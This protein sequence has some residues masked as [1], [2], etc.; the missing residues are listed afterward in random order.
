MRK[1]LTANHAVSH[2]VRLARVEVIAAYPITPQTPIVEELSEMCA[3]GGLAAKFI[4]VESEHSAMACCIGAESAGARSFTATSSQGLALMHEL[5]HW[6]AG[7]RL[8]IVMAEVNRALAPGWN[9]WADQT[10]SLAQRDTGWL[11]FYCES[12]QEVLDTVLIAY[13]VAEQA[14]LPAMVVYDAFFLSHTAEVVE[15][16]SQESVD[17]YLPP[18]RPKLELSVEAPA[19]FGA[20][21]SPDYFMEFRLKAEQ[22]MQAAADIASQAMEEFARVFGRRYLPLEPLSTDDA[23]LILVV[24]GSAAS[25]ARVVVDRLRRKGKRV[26]LVKIKLFRPSPKGEIRRVLGR[27]PRVAV[28]D[29]NLSLGAGGIFAQEIAASLANEPARP[30]IHSY[31]AGLGGRDITEETFEEIVEDALG[32]ARPRPQPLW[33]GVRP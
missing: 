15:V 31:I 17:R 18:Y 22:A 25:T 26:G 21:T 30:A 7:A 33:V 23:E 32:Q 11:Q 19:A 2:A 14:S 29:R 12:A 20:L 4:K 27:A 8:P 28:V 6:A 1:L 5:L 3:S 13:R 10:D 16:P 24:T 9:I